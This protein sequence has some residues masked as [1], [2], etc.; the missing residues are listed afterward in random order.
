[1][2][3]RALYWLTVIPLFLVVIV[4]AVTNHNTAEVNLWP[5]M[6]P[7]AFP[8]Y[9]VAFI[10]LFIGFLIGGLVSWIQNG[11]SRRRV[12]ELQRQLESDQREIAV[13]RDRL[14]SSEARERQATIPAPVAPVAA[15]APAE[16]AVRE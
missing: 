3:G 7:V 16:L 1:V 2:V 15:T 4:F 9:G 11:R 6:E 14:A 5:L 12:R 8:I 10:G 13:L